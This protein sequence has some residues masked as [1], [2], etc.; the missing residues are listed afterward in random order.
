MQDKAEKI[1]REAAA[2]GANIILL[3][4]MRLCLLVKQPLLHQQF[5]KGL[6][7]WWHDMF[8][9]IVNDVGVI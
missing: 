1:V 5:G 8:D 4:V 3:Q 7:C 2:A 6:M 9:A